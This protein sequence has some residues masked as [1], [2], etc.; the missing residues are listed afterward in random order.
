MGRSSDGKHPW[1]RQFR[2]AFLRRNDSLRS[3]LVQSFDVAL[4]AVLPRREIMKKDLRATWLQALNAFLIPIVLVLTVRWLLIEPFVIPSGSMIP[5]LLAHDHIFVNKL[6]YG[7]Q[8]PFQRNYLIEWRRPDYGDVIVFRFPPNPEIF[9]VKRVVGK[10]GDHLFISE[11]VIYR[12]GHPV[13]QRPVNALDEE[14]TYFMEGKHLV[15]Y[16]DPKSSTFEE[17]DVPEKSYFVMGDNRDESSD[18]RVWGVV[19]ENLVVG[20]ASWIWLSCDE[21]LASAPFVCHP[22]KLRFER[23]FKGVR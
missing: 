11:G 5:T 10:P 14:Y 8:L 20:R 7:I 21:M 13:L 22:Q 16:S 1:S 9:Y 18:S 19:P 12:N 15:R 23:F 17:F 2:L 3:I 4:E 6:A